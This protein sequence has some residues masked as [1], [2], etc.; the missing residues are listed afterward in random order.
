MPPLWLAPPRL[1]TP[2]LPPLPPLPQAAAAAPSLARPIGRAGL[3]RARRYDPLPAAQPSAQQDGPAG[4]GHSCRNSIASRWRARAP[5][6]GAA[7]QMVERHGRSCESRAVRR[8]PAPRRAIERLPF[9][10]DCPQERR[11]AAAGAV[12]VAACG[13]AHNHNCAAPGSGLLEWPSSSRSEADW[14]RFLG[15]EDFLCQWIE[16]CAREHSLEEPPVQCGGRRPRKLTM[17]MTPAAARWRSPAACLAP[18]FEMHARELLGPQAS[19]AESLSRVATAWTAASSRAV[20]PTS[21]QMLPRLEI[22]NDLVSS[23]AP[24]RRRTRSSRNIDRC[25]RG[26]SQRSC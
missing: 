14:W 10:P 11:A 21:L 26:G 23:P 5:A 9:V 6:V 18:I 1:A 13:P 8:H 3:A 20:R 7:R 15:Y 25:Q 12:L 16:A 2:P 19:A 17:C 22:R 4:T 24:P